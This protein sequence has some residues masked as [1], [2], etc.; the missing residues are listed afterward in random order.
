MLSRRKTEA[1]SRAAAIAARRSMPFRKNT[2]IAAE[3]K[4]AGRDLAADIRDFASVP[5]MMKSLL[6]NGWRHGDCTT[7]AG[8]A[9]AEN[10]KSVRSNLRRGPA[11]RAPGGA[12]EAAWMLKVVGIPVT[13]G[14]PFGMLPQGDMSGSDAAAQII[15]GN[16]T[17]LILADGQTKSR[18]GQTNHRS[19]ARWTFA[20]AV[21]PA[22]DGAVTCPGGAHEKQCHVD[23]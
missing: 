4:R 15:N 9:I 12:I 10:L 3:L 14:E 22:V 19:G 11:R 23:I 1:S 8:R 16:L 21:G 2:Q 7:V 20:Q 17:G 5:L 13:A 18:A 6:E